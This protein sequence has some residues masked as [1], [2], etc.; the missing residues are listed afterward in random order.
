MDVEG[1]IGRWTSARTASGASIAGGEII[2]TEEHLVFTPWDMTKTRA[3]LVKLLTKAGVPYVGVVDK[4][5]SA[6]KL[7]EPIA[8]PLTEI[9]G[10]SPMGRASWGKPP[11]A[12]V[13]FADG[14]QLDVGILAGP[15]YPNV[16][17]ANNDAFDD[18]V[19][20][21]RAQHPALGAGGQ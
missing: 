10:L 13:T 6:T 12:R 1:A 8:I 7:L 20:K 4:L 21:L 16:A 9:T 14:R 18:W 2:L 3:F 17:A 11:W 19:A 5:L 15:R